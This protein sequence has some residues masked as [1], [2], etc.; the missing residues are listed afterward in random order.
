MRWIVGPTDGRTV[1]EILTRAGADA[2][3]VR[4]GRVFVGLRRVRRGDER[5]REGDMVDVAPPRKGP[6]E[7]LLVLAQ[8]RDLIAVD[9]PAGI[10][11]IADHAGAAHTLVAL[12]A[13]RLGRREAEIHPTSRLDRDVSGVVVFACTPA[14]ARRLKDARKAGTYQRHYVAIAAST[15]SDERGTWNA[16]IGRAAHPRLRAVAGRDAIDAQTHYVVCAR[17]RSGAALVSLA[18]VTGRTHQIRLHAA[19]ANAPLIG[20]RA[21][22]GPT[23]LTLANGRVVEPRRI[24]LHAALVVVPDERGAP[25][26][27]KSAI[28]SALVD[29]WSTLGGDAAAWEVAASCAVR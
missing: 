21:Y 4:D 18:P 22:G 28:P 14:A 13:R 29:L 12:V 3:A 8:T 26:A 27:V 24:A 20:D 15:P 7:P 11:T 19:H 5:V 16:P 1:L 25:L 2:D 10:S 17:A 23:R 6:D 9:K